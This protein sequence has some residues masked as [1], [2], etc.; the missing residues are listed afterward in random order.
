MM[1][2][3]T[4]TNFVRDC[5]QHLLLL[6]LFATSNTTLS[7]QTAICPHCYSKR[8]RLGLMSDPQSQWS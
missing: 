6:T 4:D 5:M 2:F 1:H 8:G 7:K 3:F